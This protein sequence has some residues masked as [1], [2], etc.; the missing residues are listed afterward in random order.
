MTAA[1]HPSPS[2]EQTFHSRGHFFAA[3]AEA[4]RRILVERARQ[5]LGPRRGGSRAQISLDL[6]CDVPDEQGEVILAVND[7]LDALA[8]ESPVKADL[9]KLRY[10]V[11]MSHQE[12]AEAL[13]ISRATA[14]R[15]WAYAKAFLY[16]ELEDAGGK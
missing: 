3:A 6:A 14:D 1:I 7:A 15:Y 12:A 8:A 13:G 16:S 5:K 9:V 2:S 11:G 10:F 4:M